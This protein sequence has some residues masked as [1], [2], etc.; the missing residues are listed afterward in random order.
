VK[1]ALLAVV[2][3]ATSF[4]YQAQAE[5]QSVSGYTVIDDKGMS[6]LEQAR[7][8]LHKMTHGTLSIVGTFEGP[9]GLLGLHLQPTDK[10]VKLDDVAIA[11][12]T[13]SGK[14]LIAGNIIDNNLKDVTELWKQKITSNQ[15]KTTLPSE[16]VVETS[17][18]RSIGVKLPEGAETKISS[19][20]GVDVGYGENGVITVIFDPLCPHCKNQ[21]DVLTS[22]EVTLKLQNNGIKTR[23][24]PV[25]LLGGTLLGG[26]ILEQGSNGLQL[27]E[28]GKVT[29]ES[30]F[31][32]SMDSINKVKGNS[33]V[34]SKLFEPQVPIVIWTDSDDNT[35]YG[36][37][38]HKEQAIDR[39]IA[40]ILPQIAVP[41]QHDLEHSEHSHD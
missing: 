6:R 23:Y 9:D 15:L 11:F 29:S 13:P 34:A 40:E 18:V 20:H 36:I 41:E 35:R 2:L 30:D 38:S 32:V 8:T 33:Q 4:S 26:F 27:V 12:A 5:N 28:T 39:I 17:K 31:N 16:P 3:A 24:V 7:N 25:N 1:K 19:L 14:Y 37:G 21:Y 22:P 10:S